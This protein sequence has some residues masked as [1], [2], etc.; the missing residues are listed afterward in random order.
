M[1]VRT[2]I[3]KSL[4]YG[5]K[6]MFLEGSKAWPSQRSL[7]SSQ[8]SSTGKDEDYVGLGE[9]P[10]PVEAVDQVQVRGLNERSIA[11]VN[12]GWEVTLSVTHDAIND[13]R[14]GHVLPW[15]RAAGTRFEQHM[16]EL[17]FL[18]LNGGDGA[19]Y[20]YCYDGLYYF[21]ASH[22]D[23]SAEYATVQSNLGTT[24]LTGDGFTTIW[25]AAKGIMDA[26]GKKVNM[27]YDLLTVGPALRTIAAQICDNREA[28]DTANREINPF[29]GEF[30][31]I[32]NPNMDSTAWV[33]SCT[34]LPEKP[35][36][37]QMRESPSLSTWDDESV[38]FEGGVRYFK[39]YARY[40]VGYADW[41]LAFMG[42]T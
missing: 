34:Q 5:A 40:N 28:Y 11:V 42:K 38:A 13:D 10:F 8:V 25:V 37:F 21:S 9:S 1:I 6:A 33:L 31:Y 26:R 22:V 18:A 3:A 39:W 7:I 27:P 15:C 32:V 4:E 19:T 17:A 23:T 36:I 41:R 30:R 16:D 14:V 2:D 29:A 20:G 24:T 35:I 12:K